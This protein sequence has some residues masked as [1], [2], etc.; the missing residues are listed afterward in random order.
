MSQSSVAHGEIGNKS[1]RSL[2][3]LLAALTLMAAVWSW[4]AFAAPRQQTTDQRVRSVASQLRCPVCQGESVADAPAPL[5]QQMRQVIRAQ[6]LTGRSDQ[7]IVQYFASRYGEQ[8]IVWS[9]PWQGFTLLAWVV[10]MLLLLGGALQLFFLFRDWLTATAL[11]RQVFSAH[12]RSATPL[13]SGAHDEG[14]SLSD[15]EL[16][17]YR[18]QLEQELAAADPLFRR[19]KTEAN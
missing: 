19:Y 11:A 7:E 3:V 18:A 6:V 16:E 15:S 8:N 10:P 13:A 9:P 5:A 1:R 12:T 17:R 2:F 4:L 14:A